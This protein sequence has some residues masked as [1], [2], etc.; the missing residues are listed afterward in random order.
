ML[1]AIVGLAL[2][3]AACANP[4]FPQFSDVQGSKYSVTYDNRSLLCVRTSSCWVAGGRQLVRCGLR[5]SAARVSALS[6]TAITLTRHWLSDTDIVS[7]MLDG[8]SIN[9]ERSL[10][11]SGSV[12]PPRSTPG[13]W[14]EHMLGAELIM[15]LPAVPPDRYCCWL[16]SA[17]SAS[18]CGC[19]PISPCVCVCACVCV[20]VS[21]CA[22]LAS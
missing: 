19:C 22:G 15:P 6:L 12:H 1:A 2:V 7:R 4:G 8:V 13:M 20:W 17:C 21:A 5:A 9:G 11:L 10:F 18:V 14:Y 3:G 16:R